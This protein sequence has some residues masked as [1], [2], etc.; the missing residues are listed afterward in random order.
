MTE[1]VSAIYFDD[2]Q[3]VEQGQLLVEMTSAEEHALIEEGR[4]R[5]AEAERQY[6]RVKSL[7]G[8]RS[9]SES[10]LDER[11]RDLDTARAP[12]GGDRVAPRRPPDQGP[13]RR[14]PGPAQHQPRRPGAARRP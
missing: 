4:A 8:Q 14:R 9:A 11:R 3:R 7:A 1:T 10:L 6:E 5:V 2:G 12:P 13:L